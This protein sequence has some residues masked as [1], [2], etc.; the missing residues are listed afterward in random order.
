MVLN[1]VMFRTTMETSIQ[2]I[3]AK[4]M[5]LETLETRDLVSHEFSDEHALLLVSQLQNFLQFNQGK[6]IA[7]VEGDG[8]S[9]M[10]QM[11]IDSW[12]SSI[13]KYD[14]LLGN[15]HE[16]HQSHIR[17]ESKNES[18]QKQHDNIFKLHQIHLEFSKNFTNFKRKFKV[19]SNSV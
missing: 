9:K 19:L 5:A 7:M 8:N 12:K 17:L 2:E 6:T 14:A 13:Q 4:V 10:I 1:F 18:L 3:K 11:C 15:Y 16:L